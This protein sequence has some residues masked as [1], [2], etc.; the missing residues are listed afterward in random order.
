M[1]S[2]DGARGVEVDGGGTYLTS[3]PRAVGEE[4]RGKARSGL[5]SA[6]VG[7]E[8]RPSGRGSPPYGTRTVRHALLKRAICRALLKRACTTVLK[9]AICT[10]AVAMCMLRIC[11]ISANCGFLH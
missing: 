8:G 2:N 1:R 6:L 11:I 3:G 10:I 7:S 9:R 5:K 4:K